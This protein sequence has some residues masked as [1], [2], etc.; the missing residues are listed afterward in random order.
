[1]R[2][3]ELANSFK[4]VSICFTREDRAF[5][6]IKVSALPSPREDKKLI[7]VW[8]RPL[9]NFIK[10]FSLKIHWLFTITISGLVNVYIGVPMLNEGS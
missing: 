3:L 10:H 9:C 1:M 4:T 2:N 8:V 6:N 5:I 7:K